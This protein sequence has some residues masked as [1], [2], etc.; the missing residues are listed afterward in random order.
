[1]EAEFLAFIFSV[2]LFQCGRHKLK[3][4]NIGQANRVP[5]GFRAPG[6]WPLKSR[7]P[8]LQATINGALGLQASKWKN[9]KAPS[10]EITGLRAPR[11]KF[12]GSRAPAT[13]PLGP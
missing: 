4:L 7:A 1:M 6:L 2:K 10:S 3:S 8:V 11:Q 9:V 13:P 5:K 12:K